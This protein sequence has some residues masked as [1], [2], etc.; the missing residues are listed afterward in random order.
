[1]TVYSAGTA[2]TFLDWVRARAATRKAA[3]AQGSVRTNWQVIVRLMMHVAG[4]ALLT[5]AAWTIIMPAGLVVAAL[6]MFVLAWLA[7]PDSPQPQSQSQIPSR[8]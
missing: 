3:R 1:M 4:F 6:S 2:P 7:L 5:I 8:R